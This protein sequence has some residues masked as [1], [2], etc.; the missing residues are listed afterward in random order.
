MFDCLH[1]ICHR[2]ER[3][4]RWF[5]AACPLFIY[6]INIRFLNVTGILQ[7]DIAQGGRRRGGVNWAAKP[8]FDQVGKVAAMIDM[9]VRKDHG[10]NR[11][12]IKR[13]ILITLVSI[14]ASTLK[15]PTVQQKFAA[16]DFDQMFGTGHCAC[17]TIE[18]NFHHSSNL[19]NS[20]RIDSP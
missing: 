1:G 19:D 6:I 8:V 16:I 17:C 11:L 3:F 12:G 2:I 4:Y 10:I 5:S 15:Q 14:G 7:H 18:G 9:R 13:K 20:L